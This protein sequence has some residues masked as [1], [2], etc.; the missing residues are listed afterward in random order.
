MVR[1]AC[2]VLVISASACGTTTDDRPATLA[3]ITESI[4]KPTCASAECHSSFVQQSGYDFE[5]VKGARASFQ[6]DSD[7]V[8]IEHIGDP[9]QPPALILDLT[10]E[11]LNKPRMPYDAPLPNADVDLIQQWLE[12]GLPGICESG[13]ATSCL[14]GKDK[15]RVMR[16]VGGDAYELLA[17]TD[18]GD[19]ITLSRCTAGPLLGTQCTTDVSCGAHCATTKAQPCMSSSDC[20]L[21]P[22][23]TTTREVCVGDFTCEVGLP[24]ASGLCSEGA[25]L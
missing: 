13:A 22:P 8:D 7:L 9:D 24:C 25:C 18:T 17:T 14:Y 20:P 11:Q 10:R 3:N 12:A 21:V 2:L 16:C 19:V 15:A 23:S 5:N 6:Y 4:L 1:L